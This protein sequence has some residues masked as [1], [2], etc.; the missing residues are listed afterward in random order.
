MGKR[1]YAK[2]IVSLLIFT[3]VIMM[4]LT[5]FESVGI[6]DAQAASLSKPAVTLKNTSAKTVKVSWKKVKKAKK[7]IVYRSTKK[8]SGYKK[9][10]T[11]TKTSY[12]NKKLTCG[13]KYYYKVVAV[14]GKKKA[15]SK[16]KNITLKHSM[17]STTTEATCKT[18]GKTV[19]KCRNCSYEKTTV[20]NNGALSDKHTESG[21][22]IIQQKATC[23]SKGYKTNTCAVCGI[24][25]TEPIDVNP[26]AHSFVTN[27]VDATCTAS[28]VIATQCEYC[29]K[30]LSSASIPALG[31]S[32]GTEFTVDADGFRTYTCS[33]CGKEK[34]EATCVINLT[35]KTV[36]TSEVLPELAVFSVSEKGNQKLDINP[37]GIFE[38]EIMGEAENLTIDVN[39]DRDV[40]I[41][42]SGITMNNDGR[43]AFDIKK[44]SD[45][46]ETD[47]EGNV[48]TRNP[49]VS[50]SAKDGTVNN[51]TV[52]T[53]ANAFENECEL[54]FKGHGT[55]NIDTVATS[56]KSS[57]KINIKNLT[58]NIK[59][60]NRGIDTEFKTVV[61]NPVT[62]A[63]TPVT[64]YYNLKIGA[65][66]NLTIDSVDDCV[67]CKN[68]EITAVDPDKGE[69]DSVITLTSSAGDGIQI[70]GNT[71]FTANS[72][73]ITISAFK[74]AFNCKEKKISIGGTATVDTSGSSAY[75][76]PEA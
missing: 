61:V 4:G 66:A 45:V 54:S 39:A 73:K 18:P 65:C 27:T 10:K 26:S 49:E 57:A 32:Y 56:I 1:S 35:N 55:L 20:L 16:V 58:M 28:G 6:I 43:N 2:K 50:I 64:Y 7:Y 62:G 15:T 75:C 34:K 63:E 9:I 68:M 60:G 13:K 59:S 51:I 74:Y 21:A 22:W 3:L 44:V 5:V 67:R 42:L 14:N 17:T 29:G 41:K 46:E 40:D 23:T 72:G 24:T 11:T 12:T 48:T 31:H 37:D 25:M 71:G 70:E 8:S 69:Y 36:S 53:S 47:A 38:F 76:K 52:T 19:Q 33:G 30:V